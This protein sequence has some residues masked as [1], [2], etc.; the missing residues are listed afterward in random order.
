MEGKD[1]TGGEGAV[2]LL[3]NFHKKGLDR[4]LVLEGVAGK[5]EGSLFQG[6]G[7]QNLNTRT[8]RTYMHTHYGLSAA[9]FKKE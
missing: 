5:K 8:Y 2:S 1:C 4:I 3:P 7:L 6:E 9:F